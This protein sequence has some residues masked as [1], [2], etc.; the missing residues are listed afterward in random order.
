MKKFENLL[1]PLFAV[2]LLIGMRAGY[3]AWFEPAHPTPDMSYSIFRYE[4]VKAGS[5]MTM[6][7]LGGEHSSLLQDK[8]SLQLPKTEF[9]FN[10]N[11][12][13]V[14]QPVPFMDH[15]LSDLAKLLATHDRTCPEQRGKPAEMPVSK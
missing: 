5:P 2:L 11:C 13:S 3:R 7:H 4:P 10:T 14:V 6:T 8:I 1:Q 15:R 9:H 12:G